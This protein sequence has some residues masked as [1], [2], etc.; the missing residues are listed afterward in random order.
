M[1]TV[2]QVIFVRFLTKL[3]F[4]QKIFEKYWSIKFSENPSVGAEM[5]DA[6]GQMEMTK[7]VIAFRNFMNAPKNLRD[8]NQEKDQARLLVHFVLPMVRKQ[9][10]QEFPNCQKKL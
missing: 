2:L 8:L 1:Y 5:F 6:D 4:S 10:C 7:P 9:V 3:K